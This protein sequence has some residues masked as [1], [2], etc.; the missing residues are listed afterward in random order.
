MAPVGAAR[1]LQERGCRN[2]RELAEGRSLEI[3]AVT[4]TAVPAE[5]DGFRVPFGPRAAAIGY[6]VRGGG[7]LTYFAGDTDLFD[8]MRDLGASEGGLD[9]ALLP[10]WGWGTSLGPG[11]L[12]P[13]RAADAVGRLRRGCRCRCTGARCCRCPTDGCGPTPCSCC[14]CRRS[15]SPR[16]SGP[17]T[18]RRL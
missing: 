4:I 16:P 1:W 11:H 17:A 5:H 6:L 9:L 2:V 12:D 7:S 8:G 10:V 15:S 14:T 13:D 3:G 18:P